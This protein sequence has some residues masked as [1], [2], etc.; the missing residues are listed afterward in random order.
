MLHV[1]GDDLEEDIVISIEW[2]D[3]QT[4]AVRYFLAP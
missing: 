4:V 2:R 3:T 1:S